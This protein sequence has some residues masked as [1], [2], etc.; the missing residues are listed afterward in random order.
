MYKITV[1]EFEMEEYRVDK[2][3]THFYKVKLSKNVNPEFVLLILYSKK[4]NSLFDIENYSPTFFPFKKDL[5]FKISTLSR[6]KAISK[7]DKRPHN[8][9]Q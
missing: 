6:Y 8:D 3:L 4:I 7:F 2:N 1:I 9:N 5:H